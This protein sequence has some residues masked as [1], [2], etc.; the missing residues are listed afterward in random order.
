MN[1]ATLRRAAPL[2]LAAV[3][4]AEPLAA[5]WSILVVNTKTGEV[6]V[7]CATCIAGMDIQEFV[8]AVVPGVGVGA[9]QCIG[10]NNAVRRMAMVDGLLA[11]LSPAEIITSGASEQNGIVDLWHDPATWTG[12][13]CQAGKLGVAGIAGDLRYAIQGNVLAGKKVVKDAEAALLATPGDLADK[14]MA[15]MEAASVAGGDGRCS[16]SYGSPNSC[17]SPPP[18]FTHSAYNGS[19]VVARVGD[20][21]GVCNGAQGC[22]NGNYYLSLSVVSGPNKPP[23]IPWLRSLYDAWRAAQIGRPDAILS[24]VDAGADSLVADGV[25]RMPVSVRLFDIAQSPLL[26]GGALVSLVNDSGTPPVALPGPVVD[27]G[28]GSYSFELRAGTAPGM[29]LWRIVVDDH[30]GKPVSL[31]PPLAVRVDPLAQLH[32]GRDQVGAS[33]GGWVPLTINLGPPG[34]F[35]RVLA[36]TSGV[37]PGSPFQGTVLPLNRDPFMTLVATR[38]NTALLPGTRGFLDATGRAEA[39]FAPPPG[40]LSASVGGRVE[41]SVIFRDAAGTSV[42]APS[43]FDVLP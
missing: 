16:C 42:A 25:S 5:T 2:V 20:S 18:S 17:G 8:P 12:P 39:A 3:C 31:Y 23:P 10:D 30:T 19:V 32:V 21:L 43:G 9:A 36:S 11:G 35:Y 26:S 4:I 6:G 40:L 1:L 15:A 41:W 14:L 7:G 13:V 22:A 38:A 27:H 33:S 24:L 34:A 29:D 37:Q 28:D